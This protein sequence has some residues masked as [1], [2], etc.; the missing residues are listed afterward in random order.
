MNPVFWFIVILLLV[1]LWFVLVPV[2]RAIGGMFNKV[3]DNANKT[4]FDEDEG[5]K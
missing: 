3:T 5:E 4:I 1:A 2:F